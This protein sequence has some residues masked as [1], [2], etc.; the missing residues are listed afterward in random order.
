MRWG[1]IAGL[2]SAIAASFMVGYIVR[3]GLGRLAR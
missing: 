2:T 1:E 3:N